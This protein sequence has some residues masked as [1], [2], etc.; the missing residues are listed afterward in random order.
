MDKDTKKDVYPHDWR[1]VVVH[2]KCEINIYSKRVALVVVGSATY[3]TGVENDHLLMDYDNHFQELIN[4]YRLLRTRDTRG[5]MRVYY[6][7]C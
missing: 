4:R 7:H 1:G 5:N 6:K 2:F 3:S